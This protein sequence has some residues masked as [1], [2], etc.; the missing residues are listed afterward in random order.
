VPFH[1]LPDEQAF[2]LQSLHAFYHIL[3][4]GWLRLSWFYEIAFFLKTRGGDRQLWCELARELAEAPRLREM[5][6]VVSELT[7]LLFRVPI[8]SQIRSWQAG[9]RSPVRVWIDNYARKWI[10]GRKRLD[11]FTLF[12]TRKLPL[13]LYQQYMAGAVG[14]GILRQLVPTARLS[15]VAHTVTA[16][17]STA[18]RPEFR[19]R[20]RLLR[21][22]LFH[23]GADLRY[24]WEVPRWKWLNMKYKSAIALHGSKRQQVIEMSGTDSPILNGPPS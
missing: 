23:M 1:A 9:I 24:L 8:P 4:N 5:V 22:S 16:K 3:G 10:L 13:F 2:L 6:A 17:P 20:E 11:E 14:A 18:F 7:A 15:R 21:R 12:S 19:R